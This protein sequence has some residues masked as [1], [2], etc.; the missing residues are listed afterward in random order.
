MPGRPGPAL[1][2]PNL[3]I[4]R[5]KSQTAR[6][7]ATAGRGLSVRPDRAPQWPRARDSPSHCGARLSKA[8][9]ARAAG[10][11]KGS[12]SRRSPASRVQGDQRGHKITTAAAALNATMVSSLEPRSATH[13]SH[14]PMYLHLHSTSRDGAGGRRSSFLLSSSPACRERPLDVPGRS[15]GCQDARKRASQRRGMVQ[16]LAHC[17]GLDTYRGRGWALLG[18]LAPHAGS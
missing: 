7:V 17:C 2:E 3:R 18:P 11:K 4:C 10:E 14:V 12:C 13:P 15:I 6:C 16:G 9:R 5:E 1:G 8:H